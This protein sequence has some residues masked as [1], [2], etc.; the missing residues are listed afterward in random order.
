MVL[1]NYVY[2]L[3]TG[4]RDILKLDY[5][6]CGHLRKEGG[7][8]R[9]VLSKFVKCKIHAVYKSFYSWVNVI[10]ISIVCHTTFKHGSS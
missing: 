2:Y 7:I 4:A 5:E 8:E 9:S 10:V 1:N 6:K 3:S